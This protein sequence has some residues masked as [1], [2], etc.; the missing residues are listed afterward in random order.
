[1]DPSVFAPLRLFR[2]VALLEGSSFLM[3]L[4]IAMPLKYWAGMP[5]A[6]RVLGGL[7]GALF[8]AYALLAGVLLARGQW[9]F[10]RTAIA[11]GASLLPFG[12][13]IFDRSVQRE[14]GSAAQS[15][16]VA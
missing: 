10:K 9:T 8:V 4:G 14:L 3:L 12:T 13:F 7:H 15:A 2:L 1:M 11:M 6:V 16:S 5:A